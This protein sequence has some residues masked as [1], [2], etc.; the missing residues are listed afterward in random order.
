MLMQSPLM[1]S[2][3]KWIA[4][5]NPIYLFALS[6]IV[7]LILLVLDGMLYSG[8]I[9]MV[10][11]LVLFILLSTWNL[12]V[13]LGKNESLKHHWINVWI[14]ALVLSIQLLTFCIY[15]PHY[16]SAKAADVVER[17]MENVKVIETH[18]IDTLEPLSP[19]VEKGY[20]FSCE[21]ATTARSFMVF[22]NP[23]S[24]D[25]YEMK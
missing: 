18:T 9:S 23:I 5:P 4:A 17:S 19:F 12:F 6:G 2:K 25:Y 7:Y 11:S 1:H 13:G 14:S 16:T 20:V 15:I 24:G 22:F 10:F 8:V 3:R 21:E